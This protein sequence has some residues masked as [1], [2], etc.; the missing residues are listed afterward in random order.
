[1][2]DTHAGNPT[3]RPPGPDR[4]HDGLLEATLH[5]VQ[6]S[7]LV[8]P[9]G[10]RRGVWSLVETYCSCWPSCPRSGSS[11]LAQ[12]RLLLGSCLVPR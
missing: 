7:F 8:D 9:V 12:G 5:G 11:V 3:E 6:L 10:H 2:L 1:M 4:I